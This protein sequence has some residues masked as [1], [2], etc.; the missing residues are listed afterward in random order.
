MTAFIDAR[1]DGLP[2]VIRGRI[3][4]IGAGA[5]GITLARKLAEKEAGVLLVEAGG[6]DIDGR[7]QSLFAGRHLGLQYFD[8]ASCR[9]RY[10]G[11][12]TNHW[13]GYCRANDR[14]DYE[15]RPELGLP[16]WPFGHDELEPYILEAGRSLG[17]AADAFE[18]HMVIAAAGLDAAQLV[19]D[20]SDVLI[21]KT[22]QLAQD[23]RLGQIWRDEIVASPNLTPYLNLNVTAVRL[24]PDAR[25]VS[26]LEAATTT[27][28][29]YRIEATQ[30]VLC[31]HAIENARLLLASNDVM[32]AGVGNA[33][34]HVG[35]YF[36]DHIHIL[37][38]RFIPSDRF[39]ALYDWGFATQHYL[40]ANISFSD[41]ALRREGLLNYYC[42]FVPQYVTE[43]TRDALKNVVWGFR[44][45][46]D[47]D[48]LADVAQVMTEL[49]GA[50]HLE[51]SR[52]GLAY[53]APEY[54]LLD[55]RIE[56]A[57][58]SD[59]RVVLSDR[60]DGIGNLIADLDWR[61]NDHDIESFRKGQAAVGRELAALGYGRIEE[62]DITRDLVES[63][64]E[65]HYH[66]IGT[67]RMSVDPS[68]GVV[69]ANC[70]VHGISN[71]HIGGSSVFPTAG[72]AGPTMMIIAMAMRQ[73][74]YLNSLS[75]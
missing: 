32:Q 54:Y 15:G 65:G 25:Q 72:Y 55:H 33:H 42:R 16:A 46:G 41:D 1:E 18:P 59:S 44:A 52:R 40:N 43:Q 21:T 68:A 66:H 4:V 50:T 57:P 51:L 14:L 24:T 8:L 20:V 75:G 11:G 34:D 67:T 12:T 35:R 3:C 28:K 62:E 36:M 45:P 58:N 70:Q 47:L 64:V 56:Q 60:R 63:R 5:A 39:P 7:T 38:S 19:D 13:S 23:I 71:L 9:L 17:I 29:R 2:E 26:H 27:G 48:Y 31:C 6:L 73:A 74:E 37:A 30:F 61:L 22:F 69:D 10:F 53:Y 49:T